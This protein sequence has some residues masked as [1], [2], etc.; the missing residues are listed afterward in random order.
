MRKIG[1][2]S[3]PFQAYKIKLQNGDSIKELFDTKEKAEQYALANLVDAQYEIIYIDTDLFGI[4]NNKN[5]ENTNQIKR[6]MD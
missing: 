1:K 6:K 4:Y 3:K 2:S 5:N